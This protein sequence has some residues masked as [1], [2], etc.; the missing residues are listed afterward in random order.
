MLVKQYVRHWC[1]MGRDDLHF[2]LRIPEGLK[3]KI[4]KAAEENRRSMTAEIVARLE[5][6]FIVSSYAE[7][8]EIMG[9]K[10]DLDRKAQDT[11]HVQQQLATIEKKLDNLLRIEE[12]YRAEAERSKGKK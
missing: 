8:L 4:E 11:A 3:G 2:R 1:G 6:T 12:H 5:D 7:S 9:V 10:S